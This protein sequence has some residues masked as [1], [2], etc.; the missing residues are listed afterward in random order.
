ML[1]GEPD[2]TFTTC[3]IIMLEKQRYHSNTFTTF[4]HFTHVFFWALPESPLKDYSSYRLNTLGLVCLWY[5]LF[6]SHTLSVD[7]FY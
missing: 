2:Y 3:P 6:E 1:V 7:K 4:T 5:Q